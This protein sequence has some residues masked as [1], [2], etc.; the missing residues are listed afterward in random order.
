[1]NDINFTMGLLESILK[2]TSQDDLSFAE[3]ASLFAALKVIEADLGEYIDEGRGWDRGYA[4]EKLG[5][6]VWSV[7]AALGFDIDNGHPAGQHRSWAWGSLSTLKD[8]LHV[9][10]KAT[11]ST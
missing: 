5:K 3:R 6:F 9:S 1:L 10:N 11:D 7:S 8:V 2:E 4:R